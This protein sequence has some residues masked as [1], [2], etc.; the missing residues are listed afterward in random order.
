[1]VEKKFIQVH[2]EFK[3]NC[4]VCKSYGMELKYKL[5]D[6]RYGYPGLYQL[7]RC[8][9]CGHCFIDKLFSSEEISKLYSSYY[10]RRTFDLTQ[11]TPVKEPIGLHAWLNGEK[12]SAYCWVPQNVRILDIGCGFGETLA[13]HTSR[14]CDAY[15]VEVDENAKRAAERFGFN[16]QIGLF[17]STMFPENFFDYITM[18]QVIEHM[19]DPLQTLRNVASV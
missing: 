2:Y 16:I 18:D 10:P 8:P 12:R 7:M 11:F 19:T 14:G 13:Y 5:Y 15:G 1:M 4:P 17:N 6:D 9:Q 3:V